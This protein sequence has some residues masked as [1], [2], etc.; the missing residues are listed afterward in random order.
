[1]IQSFWVENQNGD[2]LELSMSNSGTEHGLVIFNVEGLGSPVATTNGAGGPNFDGMKVSS[3]VADARQIVI[4]LAVSGFGDREEAARATVYKYFPVKQK[5][6]LEVHTDRNEL[7]VDA[8]V[9]QNEANLFATVENF[10]ISL[11]CPQPYFKDV[12]EREYYLY[13]GAGFPLFEFPFSNESLTEDLLV[14]G[15]ASL[16]PTAVILYESAVATGVDMQLNFLGLVEDVTIYNTNGN[17]VMRIDLSDAE[18]YFGSPVKAGDRLV[19]NTRTGE[20]SI[21]FVRGGEYYNLLN[22]VYINSDWTEIRP[23]ENNVVVKAV[24]G[25][26]L[27]TTDIRFRPLREA[28]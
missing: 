5:I 11:V 4:T 15:E 26:D 10:V 16:S 2:R 17:Q 1:M 23:G 8:I 14:F 3:V 28:V 19:I 6:R 21:F 24:T 9:E 22:G 13:D 12:S 25:E 7:F 27:I 20:K 18:T